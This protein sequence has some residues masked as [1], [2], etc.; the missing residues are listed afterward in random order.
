MTIKFV[1]SC[2]KR[3]RARDDMAL[4]RS[5]CPRCGSPVGIPTNRPLAD[6][7]MA[8]LTPQ[9]RRRLQGYRPQPDPAP[10]APAPPRP[11]V[12]V[13][14]VLER[15]ADAGL[16]AA[17]PQPLDP[18][19][20]RQIKVAAPHRQPRVWPLETRWYHCLA[21]PFRA[22]PVVGGLAAGLTLWWGLAVHLLPELDDLR[23]D[24]PGGYLAAVGAA[25]ASLAAL[26]AYAVGF[27]DCV[28][29]GGVVGELHLVRWPGTNLKL[30]ACSVAVWAL[31]FLAGPVV[32]AGLAWWLWLA[33]GV[34]TVLDWIIIAELTALALAGWLLGITA[35][36]QRDHLAGLAPPRL[37]AMLRQL[38]PRLF[39]AA[40][41]G[42]VLALAQAGW[43]L[44][45]LERLHTDPPLGWLALA[46]CWLGG[47]GVATV[48]FRWLGVTCFHTRAGPPA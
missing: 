4:R 25:V 35:V 24:D 36:S 27:L 22:A 13:R 1:C 14:P 29:A 45:A 33:C 7:R 9:E 31:A 44:L 19:V 8:P 37:V 28:L 43:L 38:G 12:A 47:L 11:A 26:G 3:L 41:T 10:A 16:T 21:Y 48:Y 30:V 46:A 5:V 34:P 17:P 23:S 42:A 6:G 20:A 15:A 32:P 18:T 39:A 40:V 2:G